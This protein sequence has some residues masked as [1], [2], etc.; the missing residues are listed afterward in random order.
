MEVK[1]INKKYTLAVILGMAIL[2]MSGCDNTV[3]INTSIS[4]DE[5]SIKSDVYSNVQKKKENFN[6]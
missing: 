5:V 3:D 1:M 4:E 2:A 6:N